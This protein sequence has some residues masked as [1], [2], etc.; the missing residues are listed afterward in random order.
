[1]QCDDM[2]L[3]YQI[4]SF[5]YIFGIRFSICLPI[6]CKYIYILMLCATY[7]Y[8]Y[9]NIYLYM[10]F[11]LRLKKI[12]GQFLDFFSLKIRKIFKRK[13]KISNPT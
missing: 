7:G 13:L 6:V 5:I 9:F 8:R 1:M 2:F 11:V 4:N 3:L 12:V 10:N